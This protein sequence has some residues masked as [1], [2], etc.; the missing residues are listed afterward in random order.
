MTQA[1]QTVAQPLGLYDPRFEHDSCGVAFVATLRGEAGRDIIDAALVALKNLDHRG[2]RGAEVD[3]G[4]GAGILT[5]VP[6]ALMRDLF[7]RE[8]PEPGHYAI[9]MAFLPSDRDEAAHAQSQI[10]QIVA[11]EDLTV[12]AWRDVPVNIDSIGPTARACMPTLRQLAVASPKASL[13]GID[14]DRRAYRVVKRAAHEAGVYFASLSARTI[15]YKGML[16]TDQLVQVFPD[17]A[18]QRYASEIALV[19]SRFSTNTFPSWELAQP[20]SMMAHNG[21]I[22]TVMGNRNWVLARQGLMSSELL[23]DLSPLMPVCLAGESDSASY[24]SVLELLHLAGRGLPHAMLMMTPEAWENNG[25]MDPAL[26]AFYEYHA[27]ITEAWDGPACI[28][29]TDGTL[30]GATLDRNGLRPGRFY[31]T[32]DGLVVLASEAGVLDIPP[33][34]VVRKGRLEPGR[35][36]LVDTESGRVIENHEIKSRL[37]ARA[38]YQQWIAEQSLYLKDLP[39]RE[40]IAYS[41]ASVHRRQLTFGYTAEELKLILQPMA[42]TAAEP[43]GSM[44]SDTPIAVLSSRPRLLFD[45]FNQLF[46]QVTNPPLDAI[47]EEIVTSLGGVVGPEPNPLAETPE[48]ARKL[49]LAFPVIDNDELAKIVRID[50]YPQGRAAGFSST[51]IRGLYR[52]ENGGAGLAAR[53]EEIFAEVDSALASG[54]SFIVLSDRESNAELAPIPSLLLCSAV[55]HHLLRHHNR[56]Q[57][58]LIVEAGDVR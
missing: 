50:R 31:V 47:R 3:T 56:T 43:I 30:I 41:P 32:R 22:N 25:Q 53:L 12:L 16:T 40:H 24:N 9:G 54:V 52:V 1:S 17:L 39:P 26:R 2:A 15:V 33:D 48:H 55:H 27:T 11:E 45:Y 38:P 23:G 20:F 13:G 35:M 14:L 34:Q 8:L 21:E 58:S 6:D 4:D 49:V 18:D 51:I 28:A 19:H 44:G 5:Q 29:F 36:L 42:S 46:A 37:A 10:D 7:S 57:I